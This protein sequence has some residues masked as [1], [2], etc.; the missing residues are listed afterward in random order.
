MDNDATGC[1]NHIIMLLGMIAARRLGLPVELVRCQSEVLK[2]L[3]YAIKTVYGISEKNYHGTVFEPLFGTGQGSGGSPAIWLSLSVL[4]LNAFDCLAD[5]GFS[6]QDPWQEIME[7]WKVFAFVDDTSLG[8]TDN[9]NQLTV[10]S[11]TSS[12]QQSAKIWEQLLHTT[13][14]ALN[15]AK[16]FWSLQYWEWNKGRPQLREY[17]KHDPDMILYSGDNPEAA[18]IK[19]VTNDTATRMLGVFLNFTGTF[20]THATELQQK[21]D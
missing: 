7:E 9:N 14:G 3:C 6:F 15:L 2:Y 16:C 1:Y 10:K 21:T 5:D 8:M 13:G 18:I 4:I 11:L 20:G 12:I 17:Q 19:K